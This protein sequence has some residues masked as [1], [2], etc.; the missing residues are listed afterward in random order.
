VP[1]Y[2]NGMG[3]A[4]IAAGWSGRFPHSLTPEQAAAKPSTPIDTDL[5][6]DADPEAAAPGVDD[7]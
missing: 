6:M 3:S 7:R 4:G 5:A 2:E 1:V